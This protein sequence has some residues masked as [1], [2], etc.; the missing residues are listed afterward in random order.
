[1]HADGLM[2]V[3]MVACVSSSA[4][5]QLDHG[6]VVLGIDGA[7]AIVTGAETDGGVEFPASV[8]GA[9]F[10]DGFTDEPGFDSL[11]GAFAPGEILGMDILRALHVWDGESFWRLADST[12]SISKFGMSIE[13]PP[14]DAIVSEG[15]VFGDA[16]GSGTFHHHVGYQLLGPASPG[17]YLLTVGLWSLDGDPTPSSPLH[18]VLEQPGHA[19]DAGEAA[20]WVEDNLFQLAC[21]ADMS[22]DGVLNVLDFVAMQSAFQAGESR[23][24]MNGDCTLSV[25]DFVAFQQAFVAGCE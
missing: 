3:V 14:C 18:L 12:V 22:G 17:I 4:M 5:A 16:D 25:L 9:V 19:F 23:A 13:T 24:D 15:F 8:F 10:E 7:G 6:D 1:M 2:S 20:A 21:R 11:S